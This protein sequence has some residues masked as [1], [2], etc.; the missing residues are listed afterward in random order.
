MDF[1]IE[2]GPVFTILRISFKQGEQFRAEAGAMVSMSPTLKLE[3]KSSGKGFMGTIKAAVGGEDLFA[4]LFTAESGDGELVLAPGM[5][6]DIMRMDMAGNTI[7]TEGGAYLAG[8]TGLD[9]STKGS[10]KAMVSGEGLFLQKISG[11]GPV[12]LNSYGAIIEK[13]LAPGETYIVDTNHIVAFEESVQYRIRKAAKGIFSSLASGEGFTC[14]YSGPGK[15]WYQT[16]ALQA[17]AQSIEKFM[18]KR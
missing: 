6:G 3:A 8:S 18:H 4:S 12:F 13:T 16:R 2:Q 14:E 9:I 5:L 7:Y 17:F 11:N 10:F 15:I 1:K